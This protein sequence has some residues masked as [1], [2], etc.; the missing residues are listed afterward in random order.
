MNIYKLWFV[1]ICTVSSQTQRSA[2]TLV[3]GYTERRPNVVAPYSLRTD[4][5]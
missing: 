4:A 5:V 2:V 3:A 1:A